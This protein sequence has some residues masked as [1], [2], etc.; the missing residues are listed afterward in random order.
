M[1]SRISSAIHKNKNKKILKLALIHVVIHSSKT[2]DCGHPSG[3]AQA[4]SQMYTQ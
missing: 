4:R 3:S 1:Q 2:A